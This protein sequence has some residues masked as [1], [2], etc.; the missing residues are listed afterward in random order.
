MFQRTIF[1]RSCMPCSVIIIIAIVIIKTHASSP[2]DSALVLYQS[3]AKTYN[4][5]KLTAAISLLTAN[6][7]QTETSSRELLIVGLASWRLTFIAFCNGNRKKTLSTGKKTIA[8]LDRAETDGANR[9]LTASYRA[10]TYQLLA[11]LGGLKNGALYGPKAAKEL[12]NAIS[13]NNDGYF[14]GLIQAINTAQ[15]P[16]FAGGSLEK[17]EK[18]FVALREEYPDSTDVTIHLADTYRK[19][20]MFVK[21]RTLLNPILQTQPQN[22]FARKVLREIPEE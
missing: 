12:K 3:G 9:Y 6:H 1:S 22:L 10:L 15:A 18:L 4:S 7:T 13:E 17:A 16:K 11:G 14:T 2:S 8:A 19:M 5:Q 21:A 20:N